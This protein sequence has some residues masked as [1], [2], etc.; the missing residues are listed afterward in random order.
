V[1]VMSS[2]TQ[3]QNASGDAHREAP[4]RGDVL[5]RSHRP[6]DMGW[7][8]QR[9]GEVY[10]EL[11]AWD[12][13]FEA[14]VAEISARFLRN[15][16]P[17]SDRSWIAEVD[18]RRAGSCFLARHDE[19]TGQLRM[20]LVEPWARGRGI[21]RQLVAECVTHARKLGYR[22]MV[23]YTSKGLDSARRLYEAEGFRMIEETPRHEWGADHVEQWWEL[24]L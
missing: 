9:H 16:D 21:G 15:F 2:E 11:R 6:G 3:P 23:L 12:A 14:L 22:R 18:G 24:T 20:L 5:F 10:H 13:T 7:V 1:G 4:L 19:V 17:A 8:V